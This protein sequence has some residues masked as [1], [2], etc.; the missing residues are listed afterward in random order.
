MK[1]VLKCAAY[2]LLLAGACLFLWYFALEQPSFSLK[3][4]AAR[5]ERSA[6][7][8]PGI[9]VFSQTLREDYTGLDHQRLEMTVTRRNGY[10][11]FMQLKKRPWGWF[12]GASVYTLPE[13]ELTIALLPWNPQG[14]DFLFFAC[15][16]QKDA[17]RVQGTLTIGELCWEISG[18]PDADGVFV[19]P[20]TGTGSDA[21]DLEQT[22]DH[23]LRLTEAELTGPL[24]LP[25]SFDLVLYDQAGNV[26]AQDSREY[27]AD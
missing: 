11:R 1:K 5:T 6:L 14:G 7:L 24:K 4:V 18:E 8:E 15:A 12:P 19:L 9:P 10:L 22:L 17:H 20:L 2:L 3:R 25:L 26:L 27:P 21:F 23:W 16:S 13:K